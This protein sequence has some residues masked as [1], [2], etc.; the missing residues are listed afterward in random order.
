MRKSKVENITEVTYTNGLG[1]EET[2]FVAVRS[3]GNTLAASMKLFVP[4]YVVGLA[5]TLGG[6]FLVVSK[7]QDFL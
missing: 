6:I 4:V 5:L 2:Y 3:V 1:E 7:K